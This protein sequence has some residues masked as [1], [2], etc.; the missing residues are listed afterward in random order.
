MADRRGA[1]LVELIMVMVFFFIVL[2]IATPRFTDVLPELRLRKAADQIYAGLRKAR[3]D[4]ATYGLRTRF[5]V[6][7][8]N[9]TYRILIEPRPLKKAGEFEA[10]N[11]SWDTTELPEGVEV[12]SLEGLTK[13]SETGEEYLEFRADGTAAADAT[14]A[15]KNDAGDTRTIK[16]TSTTG[17][18]RFEE[19]KQ[20]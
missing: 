1:T 7:S 14:V 18:V 10:V 6:H 8:A 2:G 4:A 9:R 3:N 20:E 15:L 17:Q 13:D 11:A 16:V 12:S 5:S 19:A